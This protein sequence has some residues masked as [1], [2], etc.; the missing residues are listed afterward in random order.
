MTRGE[1]IVAFYGNAELGNR[2]YV[3]ATS[4]YLARDFFEFTGRDALPPLHEVDT[5]GYIVSHYLD[6]EP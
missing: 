6:G 3:R 1:S 2:R 4:P 5:R